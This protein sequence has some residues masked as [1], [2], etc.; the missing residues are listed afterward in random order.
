MSNIRG[1]ND[2]KNDDKKKQQNNR[3]NIQMPRIDNK[4]VKEI[5][6]EKEFDNYLQKT[7]TTNQLIV[8][9]FYATWCQPCHAMAPKFAEFSEKYQDV[10]FLKVDVEKFENLGQ[11]YNVTSI[12]YFVFFKKTGVEDRF[13]GANPERLETSILRLRGD[14]KY[15]TTGEGNKL[16]S[17]SSPD[18]ISDTNKGDN[19][20]PQKRPMVIPKQ[21]I[22]DDKDIVID[23]PKPTSS[24][25]MPPQEQISMVTSMGFTVQQAIKGLQ[26]TGNNAERAVE[27]I[28]SNPNFDYDS[29]ETGGLGGDNV[30]I[31]PETNENN[32]V[33]TGDNNNISKKTGKPKHHHMA[34]CD[35]CYKKIVGT[36]FKCHDCGNYDLCEDCEPKAFKF[37]DPDH[38]FLGYDE[39]YVAPV[40]EEK[41]EDDMVDEKP[42][43][44]GPKEGE[45][46]EE[47]KQ[48]LL[49]KLK[50]E[51]EQEEYNKQKEELRKRKENK[52]IREQHEKWE[53]E[54]QRIQ[55][56]QEKRERE[57]KERYAK[58]VQERHEEL[59]KQRMLQF[60]SPTPN[61]V[62]I[63]PKKTEKDYDSCT[64]QIKLTNGETLKNDFKTTSTLSEVHNWVSLNRTDG[65]KPFALCNTFPRKVYTD[66]ELTT[67]TLLDAKLVPRGALIIS[68]K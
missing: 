50:K 37:H 34:K 59:K 49:N 44:N 31:P 63:Q 24:G 54:K 56:E 33:G 13:A 57:A 41:K 35:F 5:T 6:S 38:I 58:E 65:G 39:E 53:E 40:D 15:F 12:P 8:V 25:K 4:R 9:D 51:R 55:R 10:T 20:T 21:V 47:K 22:I 30:E 29:I 46:E 42:N 3:P 23:M 66:K 14:S 36:R 7:K 60:Q 16:G 2:V 27:W 11:K 61:T 64:I 19:N 68:N 26:M 67:V 45:T 32:T 28:I 48:R 43:E 1:L 17:S 52:E 18:P 62:P